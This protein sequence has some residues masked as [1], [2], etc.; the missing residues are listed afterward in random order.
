MKSVLFLLVVAGVHGFVVP[1]ANLALTFR[2][3]GGLGHTL[4]PAPYKM[5]RVILAAKKKKD[6]V[7]ST[8]TPRDNTQLYGAL[9][10]FVV[11]CL[12]DFFV[13]HHGVGPWDPNYVL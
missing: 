12:F 4:E 1:P 8:P 10:I 2:H 3:R 6:D 7:D 9:A 13:T 11:G 5:D